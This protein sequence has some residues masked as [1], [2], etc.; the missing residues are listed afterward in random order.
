MKCRPA[1]RIDPAL[2][3]MVWW[4]TDK[5]LTPN[6]SGESVTA[7][8]DSDDRIVDNPINCAIYYDAD[9]S[10]SGAAVQ[11]ALLGTSTHPSLLYADPQI[12]A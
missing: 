11:I 3:G 10:G 2:H 9:G 5:R 7:G 4:N 12:V 6:W 8:H 1:L